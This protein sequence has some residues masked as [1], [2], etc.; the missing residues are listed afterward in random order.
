MVCVDIHSFVD[1]VYSFHHVCNHFMSR[2]VWWQLCYLE[3]SKLFIAAEDRLN[4]EVR[5]VELYAK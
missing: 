2:S 3:L 4:F 1:Y 5:S